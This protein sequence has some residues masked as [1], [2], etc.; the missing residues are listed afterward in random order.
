LSF[1]HIIDNMTITLNDGSKT[2]ARSTFGRSNI[3]PKDIYPQIH[4]PGDIFLKDICPV[5]I[6]LHSG[7]DV[8]L[9]ERHFFRKTCLK[10]YCSKVIALKNIFPID[11]FRRRFLGRYICLKGIFPENIFRRHL[12]ADTFTQETF[13]RRYICPD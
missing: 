6:N 3:C 4:C 9:P 12:P 13:A 10:D 1:Y 11:I 7:T 8:H 2:V 5:D